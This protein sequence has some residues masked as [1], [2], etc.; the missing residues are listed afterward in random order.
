MRRYCQPF[1]QKDS[2]NLHSY[3]SFCQF[4]QDC[5]LSMLLML[6]VLQIKKIMS[7]CW[8]C[9]SLTTNESEIFSYAYCSF[10]YF[11][12]EFSFHI[13]HPFLLYFYCFIG[14][15]K[16]IKSGFRSSIYLSSIHLLFISYES[17]TLLGCVRN[18]TFP[19]IL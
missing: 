9:I 4:S 5:I 13:L 8:F 15:L 14:V 2:A 17:V 7:N 6:P 18:A 10:A 1:F 11:F 16:Y 3:E 19:Y 12:C